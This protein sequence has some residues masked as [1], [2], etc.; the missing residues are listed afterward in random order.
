MTDLQLGT[1][2]SALL[3]AISTLATAVG[4]LWRTIMRYF[5]DVQNKL[6][7]CEEDRKDLWEVVAAMEKTTPEDLKTRTRTRKK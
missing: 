5:K 1:L 6:D 3:V 4:V 2:L 7:E